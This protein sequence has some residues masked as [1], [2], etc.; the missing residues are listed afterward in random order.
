MYQYRITKYNPSLRNA[1]GAYP[2]DERTSRADIGKSFGGVSLTEECY[3]RIEQA[4]LEAATALL[5][6]ARIT[7]LTITGVENHRKNSNAPQNGRCVTTEQVPEIPRSPLRDD[8]WCKL[9]SP[10]AFIH[11]GYDYYMYIGT[12]DEVKSAAAIAQANGLFAES[13][14]SP[15]AHGA[16]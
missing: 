4:Y 7:E 15:Y 11:V 6:E 10:A 16:A 3:L 2:V 12:P 9:E 8:F 1:G 13:F 5:S 14:N